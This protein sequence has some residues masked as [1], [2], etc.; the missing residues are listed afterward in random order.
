MEEEEGRNAC[1]KGEGSMLDG[2]DNGVVGGG[3]GEYGLSDEPPDW[4]TVHRW[5]D[6]AHSEILF[7]PRTIHF[8]LLPF[9]DSEAMAEEVARSPCVQESFFLLGRGQGSA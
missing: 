6:V 8:R 1:V 2:I 9:C 4:L 7:H 3:G 5:L